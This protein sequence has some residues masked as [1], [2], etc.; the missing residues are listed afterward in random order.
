M[1][2][3]D[4]KRKKSQ[5]KARQLS[6][7]ACII[8][9]FSASS[10]RLPP[11]LFSAKGNS[12]VDPRANAN[13]FRS[14]FHAPRRDGPEDL[15]CQQEETVLMT[16]GSQA[17][18]SETVCGPER[19]LTR[20]FL[21]LR[22]PFDRHEANVRVRRL[23]QRRPPLSRLAISFVF[24]F[25]TTSTLTLVLQSSSFMRLQGIFIF[26]FPDDGV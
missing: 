11:S 10:R 17:C 21:R 6:I 26:E 15:A 12:K 13:W 24:Q 20:L 14:M 19:R 1:K 4:K 16:P 9:S 23:P 22:R 2:G 8:S 25:P 18:P 3:R 5:R 7:F